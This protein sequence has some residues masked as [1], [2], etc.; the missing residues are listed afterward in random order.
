M[1]KKTLWKFGL[2]A[3]AVVA[4]LILSM[5]MAEARPGGGHS[6]S[7]SRSGSGGGSGS[8]GLGTLI[9]ELLR[10]LWC[11]GPVGKIVIIAIVAAIIYFVFIR[12]GSSSDDSDESGP[13]ARNFSLENMS[14]KNAV[15]DFDDAF[16]TV[17]FKDFVGLLFMRYMTLR[18]T[19]SNFNEIRPFFSSHAL[20]NEDI[21][22]TAKYSEVAIN[23]II[24]NGAYQENGF[25]FVNVSI[26]ADYTR[27]PLGGTP[28]RQQSSISM[29]LKRSINAH[30][31]EPKDSTRICCPHCGANENFT[32]AGT[33]SHCGQ[34][35]VPGESSWVVTSI[36]GKNKVVSLKSTF[37]NYTNSD[38]ATMEITTPT[39]ANMQTT[40][41]AMAL[42]AGMNDYALFCMDFNDNVVRPAIMAIYNAWSENNLKSC[43]HLLSDRQYESMK[44]W[45]DYLAQH[46]VRNKMEKI[47]INRIR[48]VDAQIDKFYDSIVCEIEISCADYMLDKD[49]QKLA[50]HTNAKPFRE[51]FTFVRGAEA[52]K[53]KKFSIGTCPS[54]GAP[55]DAMG[56]SA[57]CE[58]CGTKISTGKF[59]WVLAGIEQVC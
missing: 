59:S 11:A 54:C 28:T 22:D 10:L 42:K 30:T 20:T 53:S 36:N 29:K 35:I 21:N 8:G 13:V 58:Y 56:E 55:A 31:V 49:G 48:I 51:L 14:I 40:I 24:I 43:R 4:V 9:F 52:D 33:C 17:V 38:D 39:S 6:S 3:L 12:K 37:L 46:G 25:T 16:S 7:H 50:G 47:N 23:S 26:R 1:N 27:T 41:A 57:I 34:A 18:G 5:D 45:T 32:D 2:V 19:G 44:I 15:K